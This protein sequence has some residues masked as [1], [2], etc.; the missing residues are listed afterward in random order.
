[1]SDQTIELNPAKKRPSVR[2]EVVSGPHAGESWT[3]E[4][5]DPVTIGRRSPANLRLPIDEGLSGVHCKVEIDGMQLRVT[6]L[7]S[8]NGTRLNGLRVQS[9][10]VRPDDVVAIGQSELQLSVLGGASDGDAKARSPEA[11]S[12]PA[13]PLRPSVSG[14]TGAPEETIDAAGADLSWS[15]D[16]VDGQQTLPRKFSNYQLLEMIGQGGM[17]TVYR[18]VQSES[19]ATVAIKL[20]RSG[21]KPSKKQ[22]SLF[23]REGKLITHLKHP[24]IVRAYEMG[25]HENQP[26]LAMEYLPTV[27]LLG[28][29]TNLNPEARIRT[30]AWVV[31]R[32][33]QALHYAHGE[34]IVHRDVKIANL[35]AFRERHR[36]QV[37]LADFGLAKIIVDSVPNG[38]IRI[39]RK[40]TAPLVPDR[41]AT[42]EAMAKDLYP[43]HQRR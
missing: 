4:L 16:D 18:A 40:A 13:Q 21:G 2:I 11:S 27:D 43:F 5:D 39:I 31:S 22:L 10:T 19:G 32:L 7:G 9:G 15:A 6:D 35:L 17:A 3:V 28:V 8:S 20:I 37:K 34:G 1:M 36:L 33:L 38:L 25:F 29:M 26:Y 23:S 42:A 41:Y 14:A 30:A 24:R 12:S